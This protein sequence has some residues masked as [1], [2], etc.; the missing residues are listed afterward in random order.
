MNV[1]FIRSTLVLALFFSFPA[2]ACEDWFNL[3]KIK[4]DENCESLCR[5]AKVDMATYMCHNQCEQLCKKTIIQ[6]KE[7][8][9]GLTEDEIAFCKVNPVNCAIAYKQSWKAENICLDIYTFSDMNDESDACRHYV[10][11]ILLSR[12][13]GDKDAEI[14]LN[15][16]ENNPLEPKNEQGMDLANNRLG[17]LDFQRDKNRFKTDLAIKDSFIKQLKSNKFVIIKPN[18]SQS[19]GLP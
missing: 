1:F 17:L 19:G 10:W 5:V 8:F 2:F 3:L 14:V 9:Y 4:K 7:N 11:S 12:E 15:A 16:H 6:P 13:I 18:Y